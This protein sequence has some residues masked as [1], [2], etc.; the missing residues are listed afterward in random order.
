MIRKP[1]MIRRPGRLIRKPSRLIQK[2]VLL[3]F[4]TVRF[5]NQDA[6]G[7]GMDVLIVSAWIL[8]VLALAAKADVVVGCHRFLLRSF[9][10]CVG[11]G[12]KVPVSDAKLLMRTS[13]LMRNAR[14][15]ARWFCRF[16]IQGP[17]ADF[18]HLCRTPFKARTASHAY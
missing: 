5:G 16:L 10:M 18:S 7:R 17:A 3:G 1:R 4:Q 12:W 6:L 15:A 11:F 9:A 8:L 13:S 14:S 2:P